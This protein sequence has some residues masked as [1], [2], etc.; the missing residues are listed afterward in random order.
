MNTA[1]S[2]P[3]TSAKRQGSSA[4]SHS[5]Y[6]ALRFLRTTNKWGEKINSINIC[7]SKSIILFLIL[8]IKIFY[9][10]YVHHAFQ[11]I[12]ILNHLYKNFI[13]KLLTSNLI[14]LIVC[15]KLVVLYLMI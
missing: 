9:H 7:E 11:I 5:S 12:M 6:D 8:K 10:Q 14:M 2:P 13:T 4:A 1:R 15:V 3:K